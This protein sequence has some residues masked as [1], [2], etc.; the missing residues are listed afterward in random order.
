MNIN[1]SSFRFTS[2]SYINGSTT[3]YFSSSVYNASVIISKSI[4]IS[5]DVMFGYRKV[6]MAYSSTKPIKFLGFPEHMHLLKE[7]GDWVHELRYEKYS[8]LKK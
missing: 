1:I 6:I 7:L 4:T 2:V 3:W 8:L 5:V